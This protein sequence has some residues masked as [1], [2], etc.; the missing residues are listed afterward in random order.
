MLDLVIRQGNQAAEKNQQVSFLQM[1]DSRNLMLD[2]LVFP[3]NLL[4]WIHLIF[5]IQGKHH[6]TIEP[7]SFRKYLGKHR[8]WALAHPDK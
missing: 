4:R 5:F 2:R 1:F 8:H 7:M 6:R 3:A